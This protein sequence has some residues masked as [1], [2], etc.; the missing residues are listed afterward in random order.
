MVTYYSCLQQL[1]GSTA[2]RKRKVERKQTGRK[3][4]KDNTERGNR[5]R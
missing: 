3:G 1:H 5:A 4:D 2:K